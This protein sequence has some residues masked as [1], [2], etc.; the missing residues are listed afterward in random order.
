MVPRTPSERA[1]ERGDAV[2]AGFVRRSLHPGLVDLNVI[3]AGGEQVLDFFVHRGCV[4]QRDGFLVFVELVHRL[5]GHG[6]RTGHGDLDLPVRVSPQ[7]LDIA[8]LYRVLSPDLALDARDQNLM[9]AAAG[10]L[11]GII[12]VEPFERRREA[13]G[14]A[15]ASHFAVGEDV[16]AGAL[17]VADREQRGVILGLFQPFQRHA[18]QIGGADARGHLFA[19]LVAINQPVGLCVRSHQRGGEQS[20]R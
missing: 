12:Q 10:D 2:F 17:L 4:V 7:E 6:E 11:A 16:Q 20:Y 13:V 9:P 19:E 8:H 14:I 18:P 5:L 1:I 3:R 15:L